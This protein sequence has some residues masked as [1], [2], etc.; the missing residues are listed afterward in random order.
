MRPTTSASRDRSAKRPPARL[1]ARHRTNQG[2]RTRKEILDVAADIASVEGLEGL[3]IGRL[4]HEL[5]MSKSGLFGHF[6]AKED[7][8]LAVIER[9][10][11]I[12]LREVVQPSEKAAAG[13]LRLVS[14]L[15]HWLGYVERT[16]FRGGCFFAAAALEFDGRPGAVRMRIADLSKAWRDAMEEEIRKAK[17]LGEIDGEADSG[18]LAFELH[19]MAQEANWARQLL[20]EKNAFDRARSGIRSRLKGVATARGQRMLAGI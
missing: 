9:A 18:Q 2:E 16:V 15:D 10:K 1:V 17:Q 6:G 14:M 3:T 8:Q 13:I 7:L 12:F 11:E 4:A 19:A 5:G 20:K